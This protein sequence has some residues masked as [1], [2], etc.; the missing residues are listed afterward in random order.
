MSAVIVVAGG[1]GGLG[2]A[3]TA[4]LLQQG[5]T[6]LVPY[7][8][9]ARFDALVGAAGESSSRLE[10]RRLDVTD[11]AAAGALIGD[12]VQRLGRIDAL[13]NTVGGYAGGN[14]LWTLE[15]ATLE[16]MLALNLYSLHALCRAVI[17]P[18]LKAD[19]GSIVNVSSKAALSPPA[20]ASAYAATKAA[21]LAMLQSLSA[22]LKGTGVR[23]NSV[24]PDVIDTEANRRAM[25]K[26]NF[27]HWTQP[28]DIAR[29]ICFLCSDESRAIRGA[30]I[31][32]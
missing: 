27:A 31:P 12:A 19:R 14:N 13:V 1:T 8:D 17:P 24:V 15:R 4:A 30:V 32:V 26:A 29:V 11:V 9:Q 20:G 3:V 22:E 5:A 23:A 28:A 10:G 16:S 21:A 7:L 18:M 6:V 25:P 2:V